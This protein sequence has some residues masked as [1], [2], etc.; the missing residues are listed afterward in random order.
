MYISTLLKPMYEQT[1]AFQ[2]EG[3]MLSRKEEVM[4]MGRTVKGKSFATSRQI[5]LA[6]GANEWPLEMLH[7]IGEVK[8]SLWHFRAELSGWKENINVMLERINGSSSS[9]MSLGQAT[10]VFE[11]VKKIGHV[12]VNQEDAPVSGLV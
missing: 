10:E 5:F 7:K 3:I 11:G 1:G 9:L 12:V 4:P 2:K 8:G 6:S